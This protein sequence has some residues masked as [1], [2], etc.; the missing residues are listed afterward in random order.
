MSRFPDFPRPQMNAP[1]GATWP[2]VSGGPSWRPQSRNLTRYSLLGQMDLSY[3]MGS[4]LADPWAG[5]TTNGG[6]ILFDFWTSVGGT[7]GVFTFADFAGR[8]GSVDI[9]IPWSGLYVSKCDGVTVTWDLPTY[10]LKQSPSPVVYANGVSQTFAWNSIPVSGY[11]ITPGGGTD[12]L[13]L[14]G[15]VGSAPVANTILTIDGTCR[16]AARRAKFIGN[17]DKFP[18][19]IENPGTY[20][21]NLSIVEVQK[22]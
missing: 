20:R 17:N 8:S 11:Y 19:T 10:A 5:W 22:Q 13:D 6:K 9:G 14:L 15:F 3:I 1:L 18:M 4:S 7:A 2:V 12:G 21:I 16:R